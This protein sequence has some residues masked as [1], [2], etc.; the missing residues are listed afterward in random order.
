MLPIREKVEHTA[1]RIKFTKTGALQYISHLDL[2]RTFCRLL[3]RC[4]VPVWYSEGFTPHPRLV[5]AT[6]LSV[7]AESLCEYM[8]VFVNGNAE[9]LD[10]DVIRW[11]LS[12]CDVAGLQILDAYLPETKFSK[13]THSDYTVKIFTKGACDELAK[14]CE[15]TLTQSPLVVLKRTKSGEK[16]VDISSQIKS[17]NVNFDGE[18]IVINARLS[19]DSATFLNPEYLVKVLKEKCNIL[20]ADETKEEYSILRIAVVC[21]DEDFR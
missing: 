12:K 18:R 6:P 9:T 20:S 1:L 21:G 15:Q 4:G 5:F 16:D 11:Q 14:K 10:M 2:H 17:V 19:A 8:D 3:V 13:I 7:G